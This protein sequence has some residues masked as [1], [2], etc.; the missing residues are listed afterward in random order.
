M[1]SGIVTVCELGRQILFAITK[2]DHLALRL[3]DLKFLVDQLLMGWFKLGA[4]QQRMANNTLETEFLMK[5]LNHK[6]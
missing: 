1:N 5:C 4:S 2:L 6:V 3:I